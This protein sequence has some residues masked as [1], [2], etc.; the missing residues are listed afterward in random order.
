MR[1][2]AATVGLVIWLV[3]AQALCWQG[4]CRERAGSELSTNAIEQSIC[5]ESAAPP[6]CDEGIAAARGVQ[7]GE[8][9]LITYEA[10]RLAGLS[11]TMRD[12]PHVFQGPQ[13]A[14]GTSLPRGYYADSRMLDATTQTLEPSGGGSMQRFVER[15]VSIPEISEV[16]DIA[17]SLA[18]YVMGNEHCLPAGVPAGSIEEINRCN[19]FRGHISS[20][21]STHWPELARQTYTHY[22]GIAVDIA[23]R[24]KRLSDALPTV[25]GHALGDYA[26]EVVKAC[27]REALSYEAFA[28]HYL[29]DRWSTGHMFRRWGSPTFA[30]TVVGQMQQSLTG[31]VT[32]LVHGTRAVTGFHDQASMPG[33]FRPG[34]GTSTVRFSPGAGI[35]IPG[36][37]DHYLLAC[38]ERDPGWN[39]RA[40]PG[41]RDHNSLMMACVTHGFH[42]VY[43]AGP[44]TEGT[45]TLSPDVLNPPLGPDE[46]FSE[47]ER[48]WNGWLTNRTMAMG[49]ASGGSILG[50]DTTDYPSPGIITRIKLDIV[51]TGLGIG[52]VAFI[53]GA[54]PPRELPYEEE[55][56]RLQEVKLRYV[57]GRL[58]LEYSRM[59]AASPDGTQA[60]RMVTLERGAPH[61]GLRGL[62][63]TGTR[64]AGD[65]SGAFAQDI[66]EDRLPF[67]VRRDAPR[68]VDTPVAAMSC[69]ADANCP[70]HYH[71]D[72]TA[73]DEMGMSTR[74][75][76]PH[77]T[78]LMRAFRAAELPR[79]CGAE[80]WESL[81]AAREACKAAGPTSNQ[82][83]ACVQ[84][85]APRLR[86]ACEPGGYE[87]AL[88]DGDS[89]P[90]SLCDILADSEVADRP[91]AVHRYVHYP[92]QPQGTETE[93][94]ALLRASRAACLAG[95]EAR[96]YELG[97]DYD[98][99]PP[100]EAQRVGDGVLIY[101]WAGEQCGADGERWWRFVH[102]VGSAHNLEFR[103]DRLPSGLLTPHGTLAD[104]ELVGF[105]G[106][107]CDATGPADFTATPIDEDGDGAADATTFLWPTHGVT[108]QEICVRLRAV[109]PA[110][111]GQM[112]LSVTR[113]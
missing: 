35:P 79:W 8:H 19:A 36:G 62:F 61:T 81:N 59:A 4:W 113:I 72:R 69:A 46:S 102:V 108:P 86:N 41:L 66:A 82:C 95:A 23:K 106:P 43:Q 47:S 49:L 51:L 75:C 70:A 63:L 12:A 76:V 105:R 53:D 89:D 50:L 2:R 22:H 26:L 112:R 65:W 85:V 31:V 16:P 20:I 97:I 87:S 25:M 29:Q 52:P 3:P 100:V 38:R 17:H 24:C 110:A 90:R 54:L 55:E 6:I 14:T 58:A 73:V 15:L 30:P 11:A 5:E 64:G 84:L 60:A 42:E 109:D 7:L 44:R 101:N 104:F 99:G 93:L 32:G 96:P 98:A 39:V 57:L 13:L 40:G 111:R 71:C 83:D 107:A 80:R 37:G 45:A 92:Y 103:L 77:E 68:W 56:L 78:A 9:T 74:Q 27:E 88:M 34:D 48:C 91:P 10:M 94:D 18:Q 67:Y 21:N 33:P 1:G 28:S